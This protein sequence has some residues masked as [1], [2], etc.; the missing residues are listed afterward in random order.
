VDLLYD[1]V[2]SFCSDS[3]SGD[4]D[5]ILVSA[6]EVRKLGK[7]RIHNLHSFVMI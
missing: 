3:Q 4:S 7:E 6:E 2:H 1:S 5:T